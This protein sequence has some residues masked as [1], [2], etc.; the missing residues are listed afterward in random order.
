MVI[1][2]SVDRVTKSGHRLLMPPALKSVII[3]VGI[4]GLVVLVGGYCIAPWFG[5]LSAIVGILVLVARFD[6]EQ[7]NFLPIAIL[8]V[9]ALIVVAVF[10]ALMA[11]IMGR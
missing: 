2:C 8:F 7:G 1:K 9:I 10:L 4:T 3:I 6:N 5:F 11:V